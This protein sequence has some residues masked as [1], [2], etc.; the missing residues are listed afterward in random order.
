M[1]KI[2]GKRVRVAA[3]KRKTRTATVHFRT[4]TSVTPE[5]RRERLQAVF[6]A[7]VRLR[8]H[9]R[10]MGAGG[11]SMAE[12][13]AK[14][15]ALVAKACGWVAS[16]PDTWAKLRRICYRLTAGGPRHPARQRVHPGVPERP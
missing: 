10:H 3:G 8:V 7:P 14:A 13:D 2:K 1:E 5:Q 6:A 9:R 4:E 11:N 12:V 15:Q 16:N